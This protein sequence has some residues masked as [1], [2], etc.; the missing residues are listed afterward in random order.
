MKTINILLF[1][2]VCMLL[3]AI[4]FVVYAL[5][6]PTSSFPWSLEVTYTIYAG[7]IIIMTV[8]FLAWLIMKIRRK[9]T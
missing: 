3:F 7:Y 2:W 6:Y 8:C 9:H 4:G 5:N 1:S